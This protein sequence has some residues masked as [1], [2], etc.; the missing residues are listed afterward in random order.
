MKE[1]QRNKVYLITGPAGVGKSTIS[2]ALAE[3]LQKSAHINGDL[4]Y[5]MIIS[6]YVLPWEDDGM[7]LDLLWDN[8]SCLIENFIRR[9]IDVVVDYIIFPE[10]LEKIA[11]LQKKY[12]FELKYVVLIAE[13]KEMLARD[14]QRPA[15]ETMGD[16]VVELLEEFMSKD[17]DER[18]IINTSDCSIEESAERVLKDDRFSITLDAK[19]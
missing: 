10:H 12:D 13:K 17:I 19:E 11:E 14:Q 16:R 8:L 6:G 15:E 7:Y 18:F 1:K 3:K 4:L 5:N 9:D 2:K